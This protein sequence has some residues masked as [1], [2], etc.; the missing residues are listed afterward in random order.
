MTNKV[1]LS[2]GNE[3]IVFLGKLLTSI[4]ASKS[5]EWKVKY[6]NS[7]SIDI[8][9]AP[10]FFENSQRNCWENCVARSE[11]VWRSP[12]KFVDFFQKNGSPYFPTCRCGAS[13]VKGCWCCWL[14]QWHPILPKVASI[15]GDV[16]DDDDGGIATQCHL[17]SGFAQKLGKEEICAGVVDFGCDWWCLVC[18][19]T[20]I[21]IIYIS[22]YY[23]YIF[24]IF[25]NIYI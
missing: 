24:K 20:Y 15:T 9:F 14:Q 10:C 11:I 17:L 1:R 12:Q 8:E 4:P 6:S 21:Y 7:R 23:V 13:F 22:I 25:W 19:H 18:I 2:F 5:R 3:C 16:Y